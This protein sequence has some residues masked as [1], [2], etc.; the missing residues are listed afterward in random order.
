M[1][2]GVGGAG[3][4]GVSLYW[5][6]AEVGVDTE[7]V[8]TVIVLHVFPWASVTVSVDGDVN[9]SPAQYLKSCL[10]GGK[11]TV[12]SQFPKLGLKVSCVLSP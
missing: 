10:P 11:Y 5:L 8:V 1:A 2:V 9:H 4:G 3:S 7:G 6:N 12:V